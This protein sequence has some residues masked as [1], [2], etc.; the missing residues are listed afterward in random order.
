MEAAA[1][2]STGPRQTSKVLSIEQKA[3][4]ASR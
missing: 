2:P 4:A 3:I 1:D